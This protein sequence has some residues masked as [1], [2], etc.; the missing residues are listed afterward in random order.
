[1][2]WC[3]GRS[4]GRSRSPSNCSAALCSENTST[5][6]TPPLACPFMVGF[7]G[8]QAKAACSVLVAI[9]AQPSP[10]LLLWPLRLSRQDL[11]L[12]STCRPVVQFSPFRLSSCKDHTDPLPLSSGVDSMSNYEQVM[13]QV[14][15]YNW[16]PEQLAERR[17]RLTCSELN[18]RYTSN[19]FNLEVSVTYSLHSDT[20]LSLHDY[21]IQAWN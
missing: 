12:P 16:R 9:I 4:W 18:G 10:L 1:M 19:E 13:R 8:T 17:F 3:L 15:Y 14:R 6:P 21:M 7:Y 11:A 20:Q 2:S 5:P